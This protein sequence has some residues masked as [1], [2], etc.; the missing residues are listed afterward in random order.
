MARFAHCDRGGR[1]GRFGSTFSPRP[2]WLSTPAPILPHKKPDLSSNPYYSLQ[3]QYNEGPAFID[4]RNQTEPSNKIKTNPHDF[5]GW[6]TFLTNRHKSRKKPINKVNLSVIY[7]GLQRI[8]INKIPPSSQD[9]TE[10]LNSLFQQPSTLSGNNLQATSEPSAE[11]I[12]PNSESFKPTKMST[13]TTTDP[14]NQATQMDIDTRSH[15]PERGRRDKKSR[16]R[17]LDPTSTPSKKRC[18]TMTTE[19][20]D[21]V[22]MDD[23]TEP[24]EDES[25]KIANESTKDKASPAAATNSTSKK[26]LRL[27]S[28]SS[29]LTIQSM[30]TENLI[31]ELVSVSS[32]LG[33]VITFESITNLPKTVLIQQAKDL[34]DKLTKKTNSK[35]FRVTTATSEEAIKSLPAPKAMSAYMAS[36]RARS[37]PINKT[38]IDQLSPEDI[39]TKLLSYRSSLLQSNKDAPSTGTLTDNSGPNNAGK[40]PDPRSPPPPHDPSIDVNQ[41][42]SKVQDKQLPSNAVPPISTETNKVK[43]VSQRFISIRTKWYREH[44]KKPHIE[45]VK[46][47]VRIVRSVDPSMHLIPSKSDS[48]LRIY[49]EDSINPNIVYDYI[50]NN[51]TNNTSMKTFTLQFM[52]KT[53]T[54][55]VSKKIIEYMANTKNHG[56][57]DHL[58]SEKIS[59]VG[60]FHNFH[61]EHHHRE[62]LRKYCVNYI[63][64]QND[65]DVE[66]AIFPRQISAGRG[67]AKSS[68]RAVVCETS[69][70]HA[71]LVT[72]ALMRCPFPM[73]TDVKFIPFTKFDTSYTTMLCKIIDA[74]RKY[75]HDVETIR[76]PKMLLNHERMAWKTDSFSTIRDLILSCNGTDAAYIYDVDTGS[77]K[78]ANIIYYISEEDKLPPFL[79][80]LQQLLCDHV[81]FEALQII[82][83]FQGSLPGLLNRRRVSQFERDYISQLKDDFDISNPQD[84]QPP[85]PPQ[86]KSGWNKPPVVP[87]DQSNIS[88]LSDRLQSIE[89]FINEYKT[90]PPNNDAMSQP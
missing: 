16:Q 88:S 42:T 17:E 34:R 35:S 85:P 49:H 81:H 46:E 56:K 69:E 15:T 55:S 13:E 32:K 74:H 31:R 62:T 65:T 44:F 6:K 75:L 53:S 61:P 70:D 24:T 25:P 3:K 8:S 29:D 30:S 64:E 14:E 73:Y 21:D 26:Y 18:D 41:Y 39:I 58:N 37:I 52:I 67:L 82:Y 84:S 89:S 59:C 71:Q 4:Q 10:N 60:F 47:I 48:Q 7:N 11:N 51:S 87:A 72:N 79:S 9:P 68:T 33:S 5:N 36:L 77:N 23:T 63:K 45:L 54:G 80:N 22:V 78:S 57:V 1:G 50:W 38:E 28:I 83:Q 19:A 40:S 12:E 20:S 86:Q 27:N 90:K 76:I 66:L 43:T 2:K